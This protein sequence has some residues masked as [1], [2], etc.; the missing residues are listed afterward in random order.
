MARFSQ[1]VVI[2]QLAGLVR[3]NDHTARVTLTSIVP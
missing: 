1:S 2:G 3:G